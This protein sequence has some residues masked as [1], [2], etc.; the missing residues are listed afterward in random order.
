MCFYINDLMF[1][2]K[3]CDS[4]CVKYIAIVPENADKA[5]RKIQFELICDIQSFHNAI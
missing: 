2:S 1:S 4:F 3:N 5:C